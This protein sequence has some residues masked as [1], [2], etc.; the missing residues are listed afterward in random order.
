M[1]KL[2]VVVIV[3]IVAA[4]LMTRRAPEALY[5]MPDGTYR[6]DGKSVT[7]DQALY[8]ATQDRTK[9]FVIRV[10]KGSSLSSWIPLNAAL[11]GV[12]IKTKVERVSTGCGL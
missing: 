3:V 11:S 9:T 7:M 8:G 5:V 12:G 2:L 6:L 1:K 4:I 10:C